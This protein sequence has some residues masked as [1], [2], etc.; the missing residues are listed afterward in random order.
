MS[1]TNVLASHIQRLT[2]LQLDD[3]S[4]FLPSKYGPS[5]F[6][7]A[8]ILSSLNTLPNNP[9]LIAS[10]Y[11]ANQYLLSQRNEHWQWNYDSGQASSP[12]RYP[13]DLDDTF[14]ALAAI[15]GYDPNGLPAAALAEVALLLTTFEQEI[16]GPYRTWI[17]PSGTDSVWQDVELAVNSN[18]AYFLSL[19]AVKLP[20]LIALIERA[21]LTKQFDSTYY[22]GQDYSIYSICRWYSGPQALLLQEHLL[23][24]LPTIAKAGLVPASQLLSSLLRLGTS[25]PTLQSLADFILDSAWTA[26]P[27][28][29]EAWQ[30]EKPVY[31]GSE[32]LTTAFCL[33]ALQ[34]YLTETP[35]KDCYRRTVPRYKP[36][37]K[38][39]TAPL[40]R[41][42]RRTRKTEQHVPISSLP[43]LTKQAIGSS[44][45][46]LPKGLVQNLSAALF[47]GWATYTLADD[48]LDHQ[49]S[50]ELLPM[51]M[52]FARET[53]FHFGNCLIDSPYFASEVARCLD[54]QDEANTWEIQV[55]R[56]VPGCKLAFPL[57][58][59]GEYEKLAER[60]IGYWL[61]AAGIACA[62]QFS[63]AELSNLRQFFCH[64]NIARQLNDDAHD[65]ESDLRQGHLS[66][67]V[68][69]LLKKHGPTTTSIEV[70]VD[71]L[72]RLFWLEVITI[73]TEE[74]QRQSNLAR[75]ALATVSL[76]FP[77]YL[78]QLLI[79]AEEGA[80]RA[81]YE[82]QQTLEFLA[83][84]TK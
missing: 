49:S 32:A 16:G 64:M 1:T 54:L 60:S 14:S 80:K 77:D 55:C 62:C 37:S 34:L 40:R 48:L 5:P 75:N 31:V 65:W 38:S 81:I 30:A 10:R 78:L 11:K 39:I 26:E 68:T 8:L 23:S 24:R 41:Q 4:F 44:A 22:P 59:Y 83:H 52:W 29:L 20:K 71:E 69:L 19:R 70:F 17:V 51:M 56:T 15:Q 45:R 36:F 21:I 47:F 27:T 67:V 63:T 25:R 79:P 33:E 12:S 7:T 76:E 35:K 13:N 72:Q 53:S 42:I 61:G 43:T 84:Y 50:V 74:I 18:I 46:Y 58:N 82:R 57:P 3:G 6:P 2:E 9:L 28:Y 73:I 66:S